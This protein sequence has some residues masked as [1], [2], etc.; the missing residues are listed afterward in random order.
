MGFPEI[1]TYS[2]LLLLSGTDQGTIVGFADNFLLF[3]QPNFQ[4]R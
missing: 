2:A 3:Q 1:S 4:N